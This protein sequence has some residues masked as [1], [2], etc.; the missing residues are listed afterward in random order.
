[1]HYKL[2]MCIHPYSNFLVGA[3]FFWQKNEKVYTGCNIENTAY[4]PTIFTERTAFFKVVS[5]GNKEFSTIAIIVRQKRH[6]RRHRRTTVLCALW[7][8]LSSVA[9]ILQRIGIFGHTL[10]IQAIRHTNWKSFCPLDSVQSIVFLY[11]KNS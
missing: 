10:N 9:R 1:M 4:S 5:D 8:L 6:R 2:E 11:N 7:S 3:V